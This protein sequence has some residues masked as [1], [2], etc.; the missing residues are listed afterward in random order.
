[1][2]KIRQD[3]AA[4]RAE[5]QDNSITPE[6][7]GAILDALADKTE[8][9]VDAG[10]AVPTDLLERVDAIG[11]TASQ[12]LEK[13]KTLQND[14]TTLNNSLIQATNIADTA[15]TTATEAKTTANTAKTTADSNA[16]EIQSLRA[17]LTQVKANAEAAAGID[18][19]T[20]MTPE[21]I[22]LLIS[23]A[24]P[25]STSEEEDS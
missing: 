3:I 13:I 20:P 22:E 6:R 11:L 23:E 15:K 18:V 8:E 5:T 19:P 14:R 1:M 17:E 7:L 2:N 16:Q 25:E 4:L 21:E 9:A 24:L 12:N 10:A